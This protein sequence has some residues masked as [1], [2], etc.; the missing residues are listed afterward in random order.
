MRGNYFIKVTFM[1]QSTHVR[2][3]K[4]ERFSPILSF[5]QNART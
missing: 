4:G 2:N 1:L 3:I 5:F